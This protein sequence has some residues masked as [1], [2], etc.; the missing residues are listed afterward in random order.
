MRLSS[1]IT[2]VFF[3]LLSALMILSS[4]VK[5]VSDEFP[6][7]KAAPSLNCILVSGDSLS[8]QIS[9]AEKI[10]LFDLALVENASVQVVQGQTGSFSLDY[11]DNGLYTSNTLVEPESPY[12]IS[13][14][15]DGYPELYASDS[16]PTSCGI[17]IL[18]QTNTAKLN[19][20]GFYMT[21]IEIEFNDD[22]LTKD[23][24]E[25]IIYKRR[26]DNIF[27]SPAFNE[28]SKIL[29]NEGFEPYTTESL[30]FSDELIEA[31]N[32]YMN[33]IYGVDYN[34]GAS[35]GIRYQTIREHTV[36][37]ELRH[38]SKEY[39]LFKKSVYF[40]EN[41]RY[42][43]FIEGTATV[44]PI[45]SNVENGLGILASYTS[46]RDSIFVEEEKIIIS[47]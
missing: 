23:Y 17:S 21:G 45:Y 7:Y 41:S 43:D 11:Q 36:I 13:V 2:S 12:Q 9:L 1:I 18:S 28:Q 26:E 10:D 32:V 35:G 16:V 22:P 8:L 14:V 4:C 20:D 19:E 6:D 44:Y 34:S 29:L 42:A 30:V 24:Y 5:L 37:A 38:I 25:I 15:I 47:N 27:P 3:P 39:Y 46:S 33:L 40:Y 31:E